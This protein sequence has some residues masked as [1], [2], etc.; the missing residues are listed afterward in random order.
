[1]ERKGRA[2]FCTRI[3]REA[4]LSVEIVS[5]MCAPSPQIFATWCMVVHVQ[6]GNLGWHGVR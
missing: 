2:W 4:N 5:S 3:M 1:M 6:S